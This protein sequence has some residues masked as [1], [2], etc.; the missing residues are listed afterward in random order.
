MTEQT[1][2]FEIVGSPAPSRPTTTGS[3]TTD[4]R[5]YSGIAS[6]GDERFNVRVD[7]ARHSRRIV[8]IESADDGQR[9]MVAYPAVGGDTFVLMIRHVSVELSTWVRTEHKWTDLMDIFGMKGIV[10]FENEVY[11]NAPQGVN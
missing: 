10:R 1:I 7:D 5:G 3:D 8:W 4:A 6:W 9:I 2:T 11:A